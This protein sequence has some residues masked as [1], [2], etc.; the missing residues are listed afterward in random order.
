MKTLSLALFLGI[1]LSAFAEPEDSPTTELEKLEFRQK[2]TTGARVLTIDQ[3]NLSADVQDL[4]DEQTN[5]KVLQLLDKVEVIM[6]ETIDRLEKEDVGGE[7]IAAQTEIIELI[8]EAA[9]EK[10]KQGKGEGQGKPGSAMLDMMQRMMGQKPG[11]QPGEGEG[12]KPGKGSGNKG[13]EGQTGDSDLG[14]EASGG[15]NEGKSSERTI[16]KTAGKAG[17]GLPPEFQKALDAYNK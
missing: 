4:I 5:P 13:G 9:K 15:P 12:K 1:P 6:G 7:T 16:P 14:N 8:F 17:A 2:V 3:D 11:G 10:Q